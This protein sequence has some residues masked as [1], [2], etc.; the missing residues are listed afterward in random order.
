MEDM[1]G[2]KA[3]ANSVDVM[4]CMMKALGCSF[5]V[6]ENGGGQEL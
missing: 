4:A 6:E 2:H 3:A 1:E 5:E